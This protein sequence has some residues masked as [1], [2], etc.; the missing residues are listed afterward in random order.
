M[1]GS[2]RRIRARAAR[3][4]QAAALRFASRALAVNREDMFAQRIKADLED[5][6]AGKEPLAD[7]LKRSWCNRPF[8]HFETMTTGEVY[9]CCAQWLQKP[10]GD[11]KSQNWRDIWHSEAATDIRASIIDGSFRHCSPFH[12]AYLVSRQLPH[13]EPHHAQQT[14]IPAPA[15]VYL[16]HDATCNLYCPSCRDHVVAAS[17]EERA[18]FPEIERNI[19]GLMDEARTI[20]LSA[21]GDAFSSKHIRSIVKAYTAQPHDTKRLCF[22]TNGQLLDERAWRTL[23]LSGNV[24]Q[25]AISIDAGTSDTYAVLRRGGS[26]ARLIGNL[27][28][29]ADLRRSGEIEELILLVVVQTRNFRELPALADLAERFSVDALRLTR[30]RNWGTFSGEEFLTQDVADAQHPDCQEFKDV[31]ATISANPRVDVLL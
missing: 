23:G 4:D 9:T 11:I 14:Q 16:S 17:P 5:R 18:G 1:G 21:G 13:R 3:Q 25:I 7:F 10:I 28:F 24:K 8:E 30:I 20:R 6:A 12:C 15:D 22:I 29:L 19:A 2:L 27:E 26:F 31:L